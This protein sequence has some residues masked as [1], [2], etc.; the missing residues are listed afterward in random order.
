MTGAAECGELRFERLHLR[1]Q[2]ELAM[3]QDPRN[4]CVDCG[5]KP[6]TLRGD[7]DERNGWWGG[8][9]IHLNVRTKD[10]GG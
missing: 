10:D 7:V 1:A 6:P 2:D 4:R 5:P 8:A 3:I 9:Q